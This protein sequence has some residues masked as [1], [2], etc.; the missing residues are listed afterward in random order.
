M[1]L[2]KTPLKP[3]RDEIPS[4]M[5]TGKRSMWPIILVIF[6]LLAFVK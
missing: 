4:T 2:L 3:K 1:G 6:G 5:Y